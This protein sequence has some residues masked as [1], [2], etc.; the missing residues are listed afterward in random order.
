MQAY[1]KRKNLKTPSKKKSGNV[2]AS[3][4]LKEN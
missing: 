1:D 4:D 3:P 2:L